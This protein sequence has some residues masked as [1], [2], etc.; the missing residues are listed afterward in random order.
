MTRTNRSL[1]LVTT[2]AGA[3]ALSACQTGTVTPAPATSPT[4]SSTSTPGTASSSAPATA[5][6]ES[7]AQVR[8]VGDVGPDGADAGRRERLGDH[9]GYVVQGSR[10]TFVFRNGLR[11]QV[12]VGRTIPAGNA[13]LRTDRGTLITRGGIATW[14]SSNG[15]TRVDAVGAGAVADPS[16]VI[17]VFP[18]GSTTCTNSSG[19]QFV[20]ADGSRARADRNGAFYIDV[21]GKKVTL[22]D[23]PSGA[24]LV[25]RYT[26]CNVGNTA[27]I[28][29]YSDVLF[30]FDSD[31][32]TPAG[33]VAVASAARSIS[34]D[35]GKRVVEVVGHTDSKGSA[36]YNQQL[37]QRRANAV[38]AELRRLVAGSDL[39][40]SSA[41]ETQPVAANVTADGKDNPAGRA[42]NR[43][44][45]LRWAR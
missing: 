4:Q 9:G 37:G 7:A 3:A 20:G 40:V 23:R 43:R 5:T 41:G 10:I 16:G 13:T 25:G 31:E 29:L 18:D 1:L 27:S 11:H 44:V 42:E 19:A 15:V 28:D 22:G 2:L 6:S 17:A 12:D 32:L 38:A 33:R 34:V 36:S 14:A 39:R 24:R 8:T 30:R 35:G 21:Q 26:V 45:T